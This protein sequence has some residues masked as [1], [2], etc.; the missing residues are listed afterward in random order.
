MTTRTLIFKENNRI[1]K[2]LKCGNNIKFIAYSDY[3]SEDCCEVWLVCNVCNYEAT[4]NLVGGRFEDVWG[5]VDDDNVDMAIECWND[6]I[7]E[8][9]KYEEN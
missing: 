8:K 3:C 2:C 6:A 4:E 7:D 5:G 9:L 1:K